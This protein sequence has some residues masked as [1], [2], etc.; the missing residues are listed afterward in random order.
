MSG[1]EAI[2][3]ALNGTWRGGKGTACCPAHRDRSPSL[4]LADGA[5]GR[6]L[7]YC[8]AGCT[9]GDIVDALRRRGLLGRSHGAE[10]PVQVDDARRRLEQ[11]ADA[12]KRSRKAR[13]LWESSQPI[14]DTLG[15][16][17]IRERGIACALPESLRYIRNCWHKS[18]KRLPAIVARV[19]GGQGF[20][21]HRTYLTA[22][23][24]AKANV[25]APKVMLGPVGGGAVRLSTEARRLVVAE[26]I[27][28]ALSLQCGVLKE[29]AS[30][31]AALS[32]GGMRKLR[33]PARPGELVIAPDGDAPGREAADALALRAQSLGWRV[34]LLP[35]PDGHDWND[36]LCGKAAA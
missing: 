24:R 26:G 1:A 27:E 20:A 8:H 18:V 9:F 15:N 10:R 29:P 7:L 6:L 16:V 22:D 14:E 28:T 11:R 32:A 12:A 21:V 33:L 2:T 5:D 17:Y 35:A 36:V 19:D 13:E 30:V 34:A 25:E 4:S 31:W 3:R 23:G